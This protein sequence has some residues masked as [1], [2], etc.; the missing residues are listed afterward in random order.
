MA[1]DEELQT[2]YL[3]SQIVANIPRDF[4]ED[5]LGRFGLAYTDR[6]HLSK[7]EPTTLEEHRLPKLQQDRVFRL[8]WELMQSAR[9]HG[10]IA[11]SRPVAENN[12]SFT[13]VIAGDI[14][15]TQSYVPAIG[16]LPKAAKFRDELAKAGNIPRLPLDDPAEIYQR[17][18]FYALLAHNPVGRHFTEDD[19]K[20]GSLQLCVPYKDM[21]GWA[22]AKS[23]PEILSYYPVTTKEA[24]PTRAPTWKRKSDRET[25]A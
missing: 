24:E 20:L 19:Q 15:L 6:F 23:V 1:T 7:H 12:W 18:K 11:T 3:L 10:L 25:G 17:K 22:V 2:Q 5:L 14:G 16:D 13:Y 8:D 9:A 21:N 4:L